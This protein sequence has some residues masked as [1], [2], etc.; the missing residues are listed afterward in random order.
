MEV[1]GLWLLYLLSVS[2][3]RSGEW[4][5][6]GGLGLVSVTV[7]ELALVRS[8]LLSVVKAF[9]Y[10]GAGDSAREDAE[11]GKRVA[12]ADVCFGNPNGFGPG[13]LRHLVWAL[14]Q[15]GP[16]NFTVHKPQFY[17]ISVLVVCFSLA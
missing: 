17:L 1:V 4:L 14:S 10:T 8:R 13:L 15:I 7:T 9:S 16:F 5:V 11:E 3:S 2:S 6:F 12:A